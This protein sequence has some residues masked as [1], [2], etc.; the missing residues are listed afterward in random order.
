MLQALEDQKAS[1]VPDCT[2]ESISLLVYS[3][4]KWKTCP[5][6]SFSIHKQGR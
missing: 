1:N 3:L 6:L 4:G 2:Q 5:S